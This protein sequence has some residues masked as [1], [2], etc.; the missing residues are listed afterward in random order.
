M[1]LKPED[2]SSDPQHPRK[3]GAWCY[4]C[5]P[6]TGVGRE[7]WTREVS[8]STGHQNG[9]SQ[10]QRLAQISW[11]VTEKTPED[12]LTWGLHTCIQ[13]REYPHCDVCTHNLQQLLSRQIVHSIISSQVIIGF[14]PFKCAFR[15]EAVITLTRAG[16]LGKSG[17]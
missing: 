1:L 9:L 4:V 5:N 2:L 13:R 15:L 7:N 8:W 10:V 3:R 11:G 6:H 16:I 12:D 17:F 14:T